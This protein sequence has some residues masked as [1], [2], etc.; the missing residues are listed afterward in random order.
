MDS[1]SGLGGDPVVW[2]PKEKKYGKPK[3]DTH[4]DQEDRTVGIIRTRVLRGW[5]LRGGWSCE[6][7][8]VKTAS[9][10]QGRWCRWNP[11]RPTF[12][13][14]CPSLVPWPGFVVRSFSHLLRNPQ[15]ADSGADTPWR[16]DSAHRCSSCTVGP[17]ASCV[18]HCGWGGW[19][20]L[21]LSMQFLI[22]VNINSK[23]RVRWETCNL[24]ENLFCCW[25][26]SGVAS[27]PRAFATVPPPAPTSS[28]CLQSL[29]YRSPRCL[30]YS[31][32]AWLFCYLAESTLGGSP[33]AWNWCS[34]KPLP[35]GGPHPAMPV[36]VAQPLFSFS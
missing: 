36:K 5:E 29:I 13:Q 11:G 23:S 1:S 18:S 34:S 15:S 26:A 24:P 9:L 27:G 35:L 3:G 25:S 30:L 31:L 32:C 12:E 21:C 28:V 7:G 22:F 19:V 17:G 33:C 14:S 6:L 4:R 2:D 10:R 8:K 16:R 20:G